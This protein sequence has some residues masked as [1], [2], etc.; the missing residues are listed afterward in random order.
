MPVDARPTIAAPDDDPY[1]W[2]EESTVSA[3]LPGSTQQNGLTLAKFGTPGFAA[4]R[5]TLAAIL[6]RPDNIPFVT[7]R[8]PYLYNIWKDA[9]NPRGLW[10]RTTL[11]SFRTAQ[12]DWE[13]MLDVDALAAAEN[14]DWVWHGASTLPGSHDL[15][16]LSLSRG[17]SDA[18]VLREFDIAA[19]AFVSGGFDL[20][21]AKGGI[22]WLDRDTLL[23]SSALARAWPPSRATPGPCGCGGAASDVDQAPVLYRDDARQHGRLGDRSTAREAQETVWFVDKPGSSMPSSGSATATAPRSSSTCRPT[24]SMETHRD[25]LAVKRRTAWTIGGKTYAPDTCSASRCRH[26]SS[27]SAISRCCSSRRER[28]ALQHFFWSDGQLIA[29]DPRRAAARVRGR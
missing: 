21:E 12:P 2:L 8:G 27:A 25:W 18:A 15:A 4:D 26:S 28:R 24:S 1:L 6:D 17:G 9:T 10:R 13:I 20:P 7:R 16:I 29:V 22:A 19:K 23:L 14:E 5:D 3:P 11:D